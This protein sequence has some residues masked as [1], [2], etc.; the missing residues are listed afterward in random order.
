MV[1][2][3]ILIM[4]IIIIITLII[5]RI[6]CT[7]GTGRGSSFSGER[8][9]AVRRRAVLLP[10]KILGPES[11]SW[12]IIIITIHIH[13]SLYVYAYSITCIANIEHTWMVNI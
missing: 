2:I 4:I 9:L 7:Y 5:R 8:N 13:I 12:N 1:L 11:A 3:M 6:A 10:N